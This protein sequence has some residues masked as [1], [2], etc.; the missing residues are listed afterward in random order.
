[1]IDRAADRDFD[2]LGD[3][4]IAIMRAGRSDNR[5]ID[6]RLTRMAAASGMSEGV[7]SDGGFSIEPQLA[8]QV[9]SR[10]YN[11]GELLSR[12]ERVPIGQGAS[13]LRLAAIDETSRTTGNRYGGVQVYWASEADTATAKKLKTRQIELTLRKL[14]A[15]WYVTDELVADSTALTNVAL[16][17]FSEEL[18]FTAEDAIVNG[19]GVGQPQGILKAASLITQAAEGGQTA[20]TF[21]TANAA[22]MYSRLWLAS[23]KN[24]AWL[25]NQNVWSQ[26]LQITI[27]S[28]QWPTW[29]PPAGLSS[30][31]YGSL[32]GRPVIPIEYAQ[33]LGA[34][35]DVILADLSQY[36]VI[37]K[38]GPQAAESIH[39]RFLNDEMTFRMTYRVD[40][41][42]IWN[43]TLTPKNG[44]ATVSPFVV[45][46]A[47]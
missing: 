40:G 19:T 35:G 27:G 23:L 16:K 25:I 12:C 47:R 15:L 30:A 7:P 6:P 33:T 10:A 43:T 29:V 32:Y 38:G 21:N 18:V 36:M 31:P 4:L 37:D 46:A 17:A 41:Q 3:Q 34:V 44:L 22:K 1:M 45:V 42:P 28:S 8:A 5:V 9:W 26:L 24:A 20:T 39:V 2:T 13:G 14:I 11:I